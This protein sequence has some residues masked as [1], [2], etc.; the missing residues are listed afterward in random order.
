MKT[1]LFT[2]NVYLGM[3]MVFVLVFGVQSVVDAVTITTFDPTPADL[4]WRGINANNQISFSFSLSASVD[5]TNESVTFSVSNGATFVDP[6]DTSK[7]ITTYTWTE[8]GDTDNTDGSQGTFDPALPT[9]ATV[10][11]KNAGE[12]TATL[13][14]TGATTQTKTF[15]VVKHPFDVPS[16]ATVSLINVTNGVGAR[17]SGDVKIHSGDGRNNPVTYSVTGAGG[18]LYIQKGTDTNRRLNLA[19]V[20]SNGQTSSNADVWLTMASSTSH[21]VTIG[22]DNSGRETQGVYIH[23]NPSLTVTTVPTATFS[24]PPDSVTQAGTNN[25]ITVVVNDQNA[26]GTTGDAVPDVPVKFDVADKVTGG[27]LIPTSTN[28]DGDDFSDNI[29]D[30]YNNPIRHAGASTPT[31][32]VYVRSTATGASV[33]FQFGTI[34]GKSEVTVSVSGRNISNLKKTVDAIVTGAGTTTLTIEE[35][36]RRSGNS[37]LFD[38]VALVER[39]G[40]PLEGVTVTFEARDG[41]LTNTPTGKTGITDPDTADGTPLINDNAAQSTDELQVTDITDH[42]GKARVIYNIGDSSGRQEIDASI[43]DNMRENRREITFIVNG[44]AD[45]GG[46][47]GAAP[48]ARLTISTIGEGTTRSVT[49]NALTAAGTSQ[50][51]LPVIL[52]STDFSLSQ[53]VTTGTATTITLPSTPEDYRLL[54]TDPSGVF[55]QT[56]VTVTVAAPPTLGTLTVTQEGPQRGTQQQIL[57]T[58]SPTPSSNLVF[59]VTRGGIRVGGG[60]ILTTGSGRA[61]VTVPTTGSYVLSVSAEGYAPQ[62]VTF[63][64]GGQPTPP[65]PTPTVSEPSRISIS[66]LSA[67][68]GTVNQQLDL[69]LVVRVLD[70]NGTGVEDARVIFRVTGSGKGRLSQRGNGRAIAVVTDQSGYARA[71]FTPLSAGTITVE[72]EARGVT[73]RVT[74]TI[75]TG[76][77]PPAP[78]DPTP[79]TTVSPVLN[80]SVDAS[81]RPPMLWISGGKIYA[82]VGADVKAF[83][84]SV[85]NATNL[86]VGGGKLYWT[87]QTSD[88]HGTLNSANLD[89][90][91]AKQLRTLWGV[92]RGITVDTANSKLY[93][94]DAV[95][96]LQRSNLDGSGIEN[97]LRN[98]SEPKDVALSGGNAYWIGNGSG[99]DTL[100]FTNLSDPKK[101]IR[102]IASTSGI[103]SGIYGGLTIVGSKLYWTEQTSDTHGTLHAA[104]LDGTDAK[105]LRDEPIWGAPIGIAV[106]T[107]RSRLYWTDAVGR[108]QRSNLD[109]SG[110]HN[111]ARGLGAPGDIVLSNSITEP[112]E[113]PSTPTTP[114]V[115][116]STYDVNRDGT[117][118]SKD[119]D[120]IIVAVAAKIT[121]AKYDVNEDGSVDINDV[122]AV[123]ANRDAGAAAA[124][125]LL[126]N[127]KLT[128]VE[129]E[130]LQE[131]I[132]LLVASGD[133]SPA[134]LKTLIY[135][136]QLIVMARPEKT[137]LL[138]N[139]PNPFNPETWIPYEL[140]TDTD[141][142]I[143]IYNAQ[144]V[145]IRTLQLG[146][147]SAGYYTDRQ[148]AAY[149]D[150]RNALGEQVASGIYFYQLETDEMSTLRKMVIL[151]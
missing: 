78:G 40:E 20:G 137:Q 13:S 84:P 19:T 68:S 41:S 130:R 24:G 109:A 14:A 136:Q 85:E 52:S 53:S 50:I 93:W 139:Y 140:A 145:M 3:L 111:V 46:G 97:V 28:T 45:P 128:A 4:S 56:T 79:S 82:L 104:N 65:P 148:R 95:G 123:S 88:T 76:S 83:I 132:E 100:S 48:Q 134:A 127:L 129:V 119:V 117:V 55:Q 113:T 133:R 75:T 116:A 22:V 86:A 35:N 42:L 74:F 18:T 2:R 60:E 112:A 26:D 96:R 39:N 61:I 33:G 120:A 146:Q 43:Y 27:F 66:G 23:G 57:V 11:V 105:Q 29:V 108:L 125:A 77:V 16:T 7:S 126:G 62:E 47:G 94:V 106:D 151:K 114:S 36:R 101:E 38:L 150:G 91:D 8:T 63:T 15:Y 81:S 1:K 9:T 34:P 131:Q 144:G 64:A 72:V 21:T 6:T 141:V 115:S 70:A 54:A 122:V 142:R 90:T 103:S 31:R 138:A 12:V 89:G 59:T 80:A 143:T 51:G 87:E 149:W 118:D 121:D 37:K 17:Y 147:Q 73:E 98:L 110:I 92:P 135:L 71:D 107:A 49:V 32:T 25:A 99:I 5:G 102:P 10:T 58:A 124:P 30:Q 69:P 67:H 44:P